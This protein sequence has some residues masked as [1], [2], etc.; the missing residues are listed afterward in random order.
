MELN[1]NSNNIS[2]AGAVALSSFLRHNTS[3]KVLDLKK[4]L[5]LLLAPFP[6]TL[7]W[8]RLTWEEIAVL[9]TTVPPLL[10]TCWRPILHWLFSVAASLEN[11]DLIPLHRASLPWLVSRSLSLLFAPWIALVCRAKLHLS[12]VSSATP[13][14]KVRDLIFTWPLRTVNSLLI[15]FDDPEMVPQVD[16]LTALNRGGRRI[17]KSDENRVP[18]SLWPLILAKSSNIPNVLYYFLRKKPDVLVNTSPASRK[19]KRE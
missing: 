4:G 13:S 8:N 9:G 2:D 18:N 3:L 15:I 17:L 14:W 6:Q 7:A 1:L 19:R 10:R 12:M 16:Y 5:L 11:V